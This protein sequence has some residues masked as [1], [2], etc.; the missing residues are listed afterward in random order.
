MS[1]NIG[2]RIIQTIERP[3]P[4][5]IEAFRG[6][7]S[8]NIGDQ[9]GRFYCTNSSIRSFNASPLL[10]PA[11]TVKVPQGDNL[12]VHIALELA[13]PG[14][15]LVIDGEGDLSH[16]LLGEIMVTYARQRK[17]GGMVVNGCIRDTEAIS[18]LTDFPVYAMGATPQGP[19]KN[20]PGE[21]NV[22]VCCGGLAVL[23]GDLLVGDADGVVVIRREDAASLVEVAHKKFDSET[24]M[25]Q[26]GRI[27]RGWVQEAL[28]GIP[29]M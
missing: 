22:P 26:T 1:R 29:L 11:Y 2:C 4:E 27:N 10:G 16:A 24:Q 17:L 13:Q 12:M 25:L 18:Q 28:K 7:P 8:S 6:I 14:D 23:P 5:L 20:G 21:I 19:Y 15:I 9:M 3:S